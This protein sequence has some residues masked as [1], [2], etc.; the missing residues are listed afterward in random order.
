M[1]TSMASRTEIDPLK[2]YG[3]IFVRLRVLPADLELKRVLE[4]GSG[5]VPA[6][7]ILNEPMYGIRI[8]LDPLAEEGAK[9]AEPFN[10]I[11]SFIRLA[12][13][14]EELPF[15]DKEFDYVLAFN[16][17]DHWQDWKAGLKETI[18]V[19]KPNGIFLFSVVLWKAFATPA[20]P[21][22]IGWNE[23]TYIVEQIGA[24][25]FWD[26]YVDQKVATVQRFAW[27]YGRFTKSENR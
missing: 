7:S 8:A 20:H 23:I 27:F 11:G 12:G 1:T 17:L 24:M 4:I 26:V 10:L 16:T 18:R 6:V 21:H 19:L 15:K 13:R 25:D 9:I 5:C 3:R 22:Y 14:A 2:Q